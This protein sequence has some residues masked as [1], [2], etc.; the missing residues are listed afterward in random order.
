MPQGRKT[1]TNISVIVSCMLAAKMDVVT[2]MALTGISKRQMQCI[3]AKIKASNG[4]YIEDEVL[5]CGKLQRI[6]SLDDIGVCF[7]L[8]NLYRLMYVVL[9]YLRGRLAQNCDMYLDELQRGLQ[10]T[11][12]VD[13]SLSSIWRALHES[14]YSLK[15][16]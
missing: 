7:S 13:V 8:Y 10:T 4:V 2:I 5:P 15:K 1:S 16:I 9:Q 3:G 12:G 6:L 14:G 11:C